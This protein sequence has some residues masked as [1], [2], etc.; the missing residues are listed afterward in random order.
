M[1]DS[2]VQEMNNI[3]DDIG[4][5]WLVPSNLFIPSLKIAQEVEMSNRM[6]A[7]FQKS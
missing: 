7:A 3:E 6:K 5:A 1:S 2:H 4:K